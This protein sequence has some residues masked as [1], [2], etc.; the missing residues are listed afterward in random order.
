LWEC[1]N[2][3]PRKQ[4]SV[5]VGTIFAESHVGL[6]K[7]LITI[8][9]LAN[10]DERVSSH[11]LARRIGVTQKSA[12]FMLRRIQYALQLLDAEAPAMA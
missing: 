8:W 10:P 12:W 6:D 5:R 9:M 7:W 3:H 4:F 2:N 11:K 1:R